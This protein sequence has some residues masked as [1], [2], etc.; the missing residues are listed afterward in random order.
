[1]VMIVR[2]IVANTMFMP[3]MTIMA[4]GKTPFLHT[5]AANS[6]AISLYESMGFAV[7]R[8]VHI[9]RLVPDV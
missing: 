1:M 9:V 6:P 5:Y 4:N 3:V 2:V 7:R 8:R